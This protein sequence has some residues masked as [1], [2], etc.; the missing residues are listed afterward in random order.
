MKETIE[1]IKNMAKQLTMDISETG[2]GPSKDQLHR[3]ALEL[4]LEIHQLESIILQS[5]A[6]SRT[7]I[8]KI[9][10]TQSDKSYDDEMIKDEI[11]KM[12]RRLP[13]WA[14]KQHQINSRILTLF[15]KMEEEGISDITE[16][17]LM[18]KYDS[19]SEFY[20]NFQQMKTIAP[21]NHGKVFHVE[22]G[23]VR[24]WEPIQH[25]VQDYKKV[26]SGK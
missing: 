7:P 6:G 18:E 26:V 20:T 22:N 17:M 15:L 12:N 25:L 4:L 16:Q 19:P 23:F 3:S 2:E 21:K 14:R 1:K 9:N 24:I 13:L 8:K 5:S 10:R 11:N